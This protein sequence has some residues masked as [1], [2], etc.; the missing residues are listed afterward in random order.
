MLSTIKVET[1]RWTESFSLL[2]GLGRVKRKAFENRA[3]A[4]L[5]SR[6]GLQR[7]DVVVADR[8]I[9]LQ[10][11]CVLKQ[12][13]GDRHV[14]FHHDP[15]GL[16]QSRLVFFQKFLYFLRRKAERKRSRR[17]EEAKHVAVQRGVAQGGALALDLGMSRNELVVQF[18]FVS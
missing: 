5:L 8:Q 7:R 1:C 16:V 9:L 10:L 12:R 13:I 11:L 4:L 14:L 6:L 2:E 18:R 15:V 17:P 3:S